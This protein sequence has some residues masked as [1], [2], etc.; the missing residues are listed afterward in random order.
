[1]TKDG[2][3]TEDPNIIQDRGEPR[4]EKL[5]HYQPVI[6]VNQ[7]PS[8]TTFTFFPNNDNCRKIKV[9][10]SNGSK[11]P[12][13]LV[14]KYHGSGSSL[15]IFTSRPFYILTSQ[16]NRRDAGVSKSIP[17]RSGNNGPGHRDDQNDQNTANSQLRQNAEGGRNKFYIFVC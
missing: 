5:S 1:M 7:Y 17:P 9:G 8:V 2:Q 3:V 16:K 14:V 4:K 6:D 11:Y 15:D 10:K 12:Y 13:R